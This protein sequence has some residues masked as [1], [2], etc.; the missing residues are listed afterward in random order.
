MPPSGGRR[1]LAAQV[2]EVVPDRA[3]DLP[4]LKAGLSL[5]CRTGDALEYASVLL[6]LPLSRCGP[7]TEDVCCAGTPSW[8]SRRRS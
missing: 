3:L 5:L 1:R 6:L 8:S 4:M 7:W 2:E